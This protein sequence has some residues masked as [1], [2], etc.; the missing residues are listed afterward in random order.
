LLEI[1]STYPPT[2]ITKSIKD[3]KDVARWS[4]AAGL[5]GLLVFTDNESI[6]PWAAA[7]FVL[8]RTTSLVPLVAAQP[9]YMHPYTAARMVSTIG[10][11]YGRRV[12][13]NLVTGSFRP[14]LRAVGCFL[15]HDERYERL[16]E[17][18]QIISKL[19]SAERPT[20]HHA[21]H[22]D[23]VGAVLKPTLPAALAPRVFVAG[24]SPAA[25]DTA[26]AIGATRLTYPLAPNEFEAT[27]RTLD[28]AG[29][30]LGIIARESSDAAWKIAHER[31]P[32]DPLSEAYRKFTT[33]A[34][35][36]Q[37]HS[38][39]WENAHRPGELPDTYWLHPFRT[40]HEYCPYLVG[41]YAEV[42]EILSFYIRMGITTL[43]LSMPREE[44]DLF[45]AT[46]VIRFAEKL[47]EIRPN[48]DGRDR[49]QFCGSDGF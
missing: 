10:L 46:E 17:Y 42:A 4:E 13:L 34:C 43:I 47:A 33:R 15:E 1:Y 38:Q 3:V 12:D 40:T 5:R 11:L 21:K 8:E 22:Y 49:P 25:A 26:R 44:D 36:A 18:G 28:G 2:A 20:T 41:S 9:A 31:F 14:H 30:R 39:L 27:D 19:L 24:S 32:G 16:V 48:H 29:I 6:D 45:H 35:D 23:L 37:W 7:Q